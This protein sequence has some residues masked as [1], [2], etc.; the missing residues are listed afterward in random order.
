MF[1]IF[2]KKKVVSHLRLTGVIGNVGKFRQGIEYSGQEDTI[3][4]AFSVKKALAVAITINSPGGSPVQS[5]LIYKLIR[6]QA[7]KNKKKVIIFTEDVAASG[8]YLIAC[9]GDEIYANSSSIIGSIG[10]ISASFGFKNLIEKIGVQRRVYTAGKN[11]STLDPF[12][13]EKEEDI[14][15]LKNIQLELHQDFIDVVE[16]SR[17]SKLNKQNDI[18]LFSGEFWTGK[19]AKELGL[20]DGLGNADQILRE[21]F[22]DEVEIKKFGKPKGWLAKKLSSS[23]EHADKLISI[24]E[25]RSIWQRYGL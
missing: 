6:E 24:L 10:V 19:K 7:K 18:E 8:G 3:K 25:E 20:I 12:L 13:D 11:K 14:N 5:H 1:S 21:K 23:Q 9:S 2:K 16:E 15:R 17:G 4:K 22:G